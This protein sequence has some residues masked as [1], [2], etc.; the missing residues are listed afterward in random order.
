MNV[1]EDSYKSHLYCITCSFLLGSHFFYVMQSP[2]QVP[3]QSSS[4]NIIL[5]FCDVFLPRLGRICCSPLYPP[6][7]FP[8]IFIIIHTMLYCNCFLSLAW[9]TLVGQERWLWYTVSY[10]SQFNLTLRTVS[11]T[12]GAPWIN[13]MNSYKQA[14]NRLVGVLRHCISMLSS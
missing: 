4:S 6:T 5:F 7:V 14:K 3:T 2:W 8:L 11:G 10:S 12:L 13:W 1:L 9:K